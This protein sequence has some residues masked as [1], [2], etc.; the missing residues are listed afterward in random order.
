MSH[1][2]PALTSTG[3]R[4]L[5]GRAGLTLVEIAM[6]LGVLS[7][8]LAGLFAAMATSLRAEAL[9]RERQAASEEASRQ[10]DDFLA[11]P[12]Y[13][14]SNSVATFDVFKKTGAGDVALTPWP[15]ENLNSDRPTGEQARVG[16]IDSTISAD[17]KLA[18]VT[19]RVVWHGLDDR[20][21][22]LSLVSA[23]VR[24]E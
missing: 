10:L 13:A 21:Q 22:E 20:R 2:V 19:V 5:D 4:G 8:L 16:R 14:F 1:A 3:S 11:V 9:T 18:T 12:N 23:Q 15:G 6:A 17:A 7:V 24:E